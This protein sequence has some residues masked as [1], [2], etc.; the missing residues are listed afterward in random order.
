MRHQINEPELLA[1]A[2]ALYWACVDWLEDETNDAEFADQLRA[3]VAKVKTRPTTTESTTMTTNKPTALATFLL[4]DNH[5]VIFHR[6][7]EGH[8]ATCETCSLSKTIALAVAF[9]YGN[10][11]INMTVDGAPLKRI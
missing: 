1:R 11:V 6:T 3:I 8:H 7:S 10:G 2:P 9:M 4:H 5:R